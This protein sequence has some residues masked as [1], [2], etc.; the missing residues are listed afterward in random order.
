MSIVVVVHNARPYLEGCLASLL[1]QTY[2]LYEIIVVD[3]AS[4]DGSLEIARQCAVVRTIS[5]SINLGYAS[6]NNLGMRQAQGDLLAFVN[7]DTEAEPDWLTELVAAMMSAPNIGLVTSKVLLFDRR[8]RVNTI[9]NS[10][11]FTGLGFCRRLN[12]RDAPGRQVEDVA[13]VSGAA[14]LIRR[15]LMERLAGFDESF[16]MYLEDTDLSWR[17]R[18]LGYRCVAAHGSR[19]YHHFSVRLGAPKV[20]F[21]ERNRYL[22]LLK[23]YRLTTL[24]WL[25]PALLV[26]EVVT[27]GYVAVAGPSHTRAKF[28]AYWWIASHVKAIWASRRVTQRTRRVDDHH[29]LRHFDH[30][31]AIEQVSASV[32]ARLGQ[33]LSTR[34]FSFWQRVVIIALGARTATTMRPARRER[35]QRR[36]TLTTWPVQWPTRRSSEGR[37]R[38]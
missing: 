37:D 35:A 6:G 13:A 8:D 27:W 12:G 32:L 24:F 14:F 16:F 18:L 2:P 11:H 22:M 5:S 23:N 19:I 21:L 33:A 31:L 15:D 10:V 38:A 20:F 29:I 34:F 17:A 28:H 3:N 7:P 9:G 30:R 1:S 26:S 25:L 4:T 36:V